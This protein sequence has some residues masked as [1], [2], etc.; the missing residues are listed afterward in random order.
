MDDFCIMDPQ[1]WFILLLKYAY[2]DKIR[3]ILL[4]VGYGTIDNFCY[5]HFPEA[6]QVN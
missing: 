5:S 4:Q 1:K 2:E 3:Y 6:D